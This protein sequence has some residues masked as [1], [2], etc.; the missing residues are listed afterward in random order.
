MKNIEPSLRALRFL[1]TVAEEHGLVRAAQRLGMSQSGA[2]HALAGLE[3]TLGIRL[4]ARN[5]G[6]LRLS[7]AAVRLLPHVRQILASLDAVRD[8]VSGLAGLTTG[9]LRIA[10]VPRPGGPLLSPLIPGV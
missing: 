5:T 10:A 3:E 8:E 7:E 6:G 4:V 9:G 2:S 1:E